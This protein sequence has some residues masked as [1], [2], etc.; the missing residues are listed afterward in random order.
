MLADCVP[1]A[2]SWAKVY[3]QLN[4][5]WGLKPHEIDDYSVCRIFSLLR[6]DGRISREAFEQR[7]AE[8]QGKK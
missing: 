5:V 4:E 8:K 2:I 3:R 1:P 7:L 6:V